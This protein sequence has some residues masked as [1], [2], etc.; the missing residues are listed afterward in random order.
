VVRVK[1]TPHFDEIRN[2]NICGHL[3]QGSP[4]NQLQISRARRRIAGSGPDKSMML[5]GS[6]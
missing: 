6:P 3:D 1:K 4:P 2:T 5:E